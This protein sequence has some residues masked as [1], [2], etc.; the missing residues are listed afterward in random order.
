MYFISGAPSSETFHKISRYGVVLSVS[1]M[2]LLGSLLIVQDPDLLS[3]D[4]VPENH[5]KSVYPSVFD[6]Y[7]DQL[8][9][10]VSDLAKSSE[11]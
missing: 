1:L 10:S 6:K 3:M 11:V 8:I 9:L 4:E 5:R 7:I 2:S